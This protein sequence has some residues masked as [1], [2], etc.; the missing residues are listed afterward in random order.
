M[1]IYRMNTSN[2]HIGSAS[3]HSDYIHG[4]GKYSYKQNEI[5]YK[6][7]FMPEGITP[8]E[9]WKCADENEPV[10]GNRLGRTYREFK[11]TL[12]HELS[13]EENIKL[14]NDFIEKEIGK[15]HYYSVV[16]HDKESNEK[17]IQ[18]VHAHLMFSERTLDGVDRPLEKYF[19]Y[20]NWRNPANGGAKKDPTWGKKSK[21]LEIRKSW[22]EV[23]N[24]HLE[25]KG[26][27]P[28]SCKSLKAQKEEALENGDMEKAKFC[29]REPVNIPGYLLKKDIDKMTLE[30]LNQV[31]DYV[32]NKE[33]YDKG[34]ELYLNS[35]KAQKQ[36]GLYS[37]IESNITDLTYNLQKDNYTFDDFSNVEANFNMLEREIYKTEFMLLENNLVR[38][39]FKV[40]APEYYNLLLEKDN[41]IDKYE[42]NKN[43]NIDVDSQ[44]FYKNLAEINEKIS[45][46]PSPKSLPNFAEEKEKIQRDLEKS[47]EKYNLNIAKFRNELDKIKEKIGQDKF[48]KSLLKKEFK[49]NLERLIEYKFEIKQLNRKLT[50]YNRNLDKEKLY[51]SAMNIYSK[52][53]Y[54]KVNN[55]FKNLKNQLEILEPN[56]I[57]KTGNSPEENQKMEKEYNILKEKYLVAKNELDTFKEKYRNKNAQ[58]KIGH[59]MDSM[60]KKYR[61]LIDKAL[62]D[63]RLLSVELNLVRNRINETPINKKEAYNILE[64]YS[65]K[66]D[67]SKVNL[68]K[69]E[70]IIKNLTKS[71]TKEKISDIALNKLS[72]GRYFIVAKEYK[73]TADRFNA[74]EKQE[75]NL[76][77]YEFKEKFEIKKEK[78]I[79]ISKMEDLKAEYKSILETKNTEN[80]KNICEVIKSSGENIIFTLKEELKEIKN[81][82]F[83]DKSKEFIASNIKNEIENTS[84]NEKKISD[85]KPY[86]EDNSNIGSGIGM[87]D[88]EDESSG[89]GGF[90]ILNRDEERWKKKQKNVFEQG[91]SL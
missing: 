9:F 66:A 11:L 5:V 55:N 52:G 16:I 33:I 89:G 74:L 19:Q 13:L 50:S 73:I 68:E 85:Y 22:E 69:K 72:K 21:F 17:G 40:V 3:P 51:E 4:E 26:I 15:N 67:L 77:F 20:A 49:A 59:I 81:E 63:K 46:L 7:N 35:K 91:F 43:R 62:L 2:G 64:K 58:I 8:R 76:K 44:E 37:E 10:I 61:R 84:N 36:S 57:Y 70:N 75:K 45:S 23:L 82:S 65:I 78:N 56:V 14:V 30:E 83:E 25:L 87:E 28:V 71:F 18:N 53:E 24:K 54:Y 41:L 38:E 42:Q 6:N 32:I 1:A 47:L 79:L 80:F 48:D 90:K 34:K 39:T 88:A 12:P 29:D 31:N 86:Y 60:D 27:E